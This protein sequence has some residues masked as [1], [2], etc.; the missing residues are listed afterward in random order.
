MNEPGTHIEI[1]DVLTSIRRLVSQDATSARAPAVS[2]RAAAPAAVPPPEAEAEDAAQ[3][4]ACLVLTPALRVEPEAEAAG[5][6]NAGEEAAPVAEVPDADIVEELS[7]LETSIAEME[8]A[9]A[10]HGAEFAAQA[11]DDVSL[12][13]DPLPETAPE[14]E[15]DVAPEAG[16]DAEPADLSGAEPLPAEPRD[17][18]EEAEAPFA[19]DVAPEDLEALLLDT[20][21]FAEAEAEV[22]VEV[23]DPDAEGVAVEEAGPVPD[24]AVGFDAEAEDAVEDDEGDPDLRDEAWTEDQGAMDWAE[25]ALNLASTGSGPRRLHLSDALEEDRRPEILR[26]SYQTLRDEYAR[27]EDLPGI[28]AALDDEPLMDGGLIDEEALRMLVA[29]LIRE[30]LRGVLGE[31]ITRNVRKLV[32]REIQRALMG[33][34][35]E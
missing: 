29:Q 25:A 17:D 20:A 1:E 30:E 2:H 32:R 33:E 11:G 13:A 23:A 10:G 31:R 8:A 19:E 21:D 18:R 16:D 28:E 3:D 26:S 12:E 15:R 9:V 35:Y 27:D 7:R 24:Q 5:E 22:G 34:D 6:A 4:A 14:P